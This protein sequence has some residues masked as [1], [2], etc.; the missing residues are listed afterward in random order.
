MLT[1]E[2]L[3]CIEV[4]TVCESTL[5]FTLSWTS[6][7]IVMD[8]MVQYRFGKERYIKQINDNW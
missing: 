8:L 2:V 7:N 5:M 1:L 4:L 3:T 6:K